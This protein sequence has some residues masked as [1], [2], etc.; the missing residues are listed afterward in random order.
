MFNYSMHINLEYPNMQLLNQP[1]TEKRMD[2]GK[3]KRPYA[4]FLN[5]L[6]EDAALTSLLW[7]FFFGARAASPK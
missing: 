1:L 3:D 5:P 2:T 7:T 4:G 6:L